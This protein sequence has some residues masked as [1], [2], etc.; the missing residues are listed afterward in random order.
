MVFADIA[1][2]FCPPHDICMDEECRRDILLLH[3]SPLGYVWMMWF[4][5][6]LKQEPI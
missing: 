4:F 6:G 1:L 2:K 3:G 5:Y